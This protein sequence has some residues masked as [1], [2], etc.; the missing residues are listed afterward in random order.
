M[1][2]LRAADYHASPVYQLRQA[3]IDFSRQSGYESV[4]LPA[5]RRLSPRYDAY[6][7]SLDTANALFL[8]QYPD[9]ANLLTP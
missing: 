8:A 2:Y 7:R 3:L 9:V 6:C 1:E 4:F 5:M